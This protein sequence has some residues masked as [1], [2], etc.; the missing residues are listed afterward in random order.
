MAKGIKT[1]LYHVS[2]MARATSMYSTLLGVEPY[3]ADDYYVGFQIDGQEIGLVN[4]NIAGGK[5]GVI[6][7]VHVEDIDA[8]HQ[9]LVDAGAEE[10]T[11]VA[12]V[13]GGLRVSTVR[14]ADGNVIGLSQEAS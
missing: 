5:T 7:H 6:P 4:I 8:A 12:D 14:D 1:V 3:T 2:D 11:P 10:L 9:A 13:G